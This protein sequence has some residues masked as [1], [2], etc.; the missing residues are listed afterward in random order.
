MARS[1]SGRRGRGASDLGGTLGSLLRSTW[2][3]AGAVREVLERGARTG[4]ARLDEA[5]SDRKRAAALAELGAI[6]LELV[7]QGE[8]ELDELPEIRQAV[9][10]LDR[11][12]AAERAD[13]GERGGVGGAGESGP[14][15]GERESARRAEWE[16]ERAEQGRQGARN[17]RTERTERTE[18]NDREE[19]RGPASR[20]PSGVREDW[21]E[22]FSASGGAAGP[23][24][25]GGL[26]LDDELDPDTLRQSLGPPPRKRFD[27]RDVI[28]GRA[29]T[30]GTR[31]TRQAWDEEDQQDWS[32]EVTGEH[33]E[34]AIAADLE[35][36]LEESL[37]EELDEELD[38]ELDDELAD[39]LDDE[40]DDDGLARGAGGGG[41]G[42]AEELEDV[43]EEKLEAELD[44]SEE[45][46]TRS[47]RH[48]AQ[49]FDPSRAPGAGRRRSDTLQTRVPDLR[50][51]I[52]IS[53]EARV[54]EPLPPSERRGGGWGSFEQ[55][56]REGAGAGA[57]E[58]RFD[59]PFDAQLD[60]QLE[61]PLDAQPGSPDAQFDAPSDESGFDPPTATRRRRRGW[62][63]AEDAR[64]A[65]T[66]RLRSISQP[67]LR[68]LSARRDDD[69]P[70]AL[71]DE[72]DRADR[73]GRATAFSSAALDD[74]DARTLEHPPARVDRADRG[75]RS[76]LASVANAH[77]DTSR[78]R[79]PSA[80]TRPDHL[81]SDAGPDA[82][83]F[84]GRRGAGGT[85][86]NASPAASSASDDDGTVSSSSWKRS[87]ATDSA[88]A[89]SQRVWR[90]VI[91]PDP[92][93][94]DDAADA[95]D[96][97]AAEAAAPRFASPSAPPSASASA[98]SA[99]ST[100]G[101]SSSAP[102][103]PSAP[104][105]PSVAPPSPSASS[106]SPHAA[107]SASTPA[108]VPVAED[109][110]HIPGVVRFDD[111]SP[112]LSSENPSDDASRSSNLAAI[113]GRSTR[114]GG[115]NFDDDL[116]DYMH[117]DDVPKRDPS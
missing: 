111:L 28:S 117:P 12:D 109:H 58:A 38:D 90:P 43:L 7:R 96:Q 25:A 107:S 94:A 19:R 67:L 76:G 9:Q 82:P 55:E 32:E 54:T 50:A 1:P 39:E 77:F 35:S 101:S 60:P 42:G 48:H 27:E 78:G 34:D 70:F 113:T 61:A 47:A 88:R 24:R 33:G 102:A 100:S 79:R 18:L 16:R 105:D 62:N 2:E 23:R 46:D 36:A 86:G 81:R 53:R 72:P 51:E 59:E 97:P 6:V 44:L 5:L 13:W 89:P 22:S 84:L 68:A 65:V 8:I 66:Q 41:E 4:R 108:T 30:P 83:T 21:R 98:P 80:G 26:D 115:I 15:R 56:P 69:S 10:A 31:E 64:E 20:T 11:L 37:D 87:A 106:E 103:A 73:A 74:E 104:A 29:Q 63:V 114:A 95:A 93:P 91:P 71:D 92:A 112:A 75:S 3:Q 116:E 49:T 99:P 110:L 52:R 85:S 14:R 57:L 40:L 17:E 45:L